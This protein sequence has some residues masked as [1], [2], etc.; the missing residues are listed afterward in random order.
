MMAQGTRHMTKST[1]R[2]RVLVCL[3]IPVLFWISSSV[4]FIYSMIGVKLE[5]YFYLHFVLFDLVLLYFLLAHFFDP[6][7]FFSLADKFPVMEWPAEFLVQ[8]RFLGVDPVNKKQ[9][10]HFFAPGVEIGG[11]DK[12]VDVWT[13]K[14][15]E[16][17]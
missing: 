14:G 13:S 6:F 5:K 1:A 9:C 8:A 15:I 2:A 17:E 12:Q 4:I 3:L 10:N 7:L 11:R 16:E